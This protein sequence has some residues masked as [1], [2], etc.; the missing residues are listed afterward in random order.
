MDKIS[1]EQRSK[2]M[3]AIRSKGN[4]TTELEFIK[5]LRKNKITGWRKHKRGVYGSPDFIFQKNKIVVFIDG[6]FWHG[7]KKHCIMPKSNTDYWNSKIARNKKRDY[8][9]NIY[10]K[11]KKWKVV[12]IWEHEIQKNFDKTIQRIIPFLN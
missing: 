12:R 4:K 8:I 9:V 10:Y 5:L 11:N 1:K 3:S 6:C 7:C 2:N